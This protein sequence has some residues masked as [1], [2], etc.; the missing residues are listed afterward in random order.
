L[1]YVSLMAT[2]VALVPLGA[3]I[4]S[5]LVSLVGTAAIIYGFGKTRAYVGDAT[6]DI[7]DMKFTRW[8]GKMINSILIVS[9]SLPFVIVVMYFVGWHLFTSD[10]RWIIQML[11]LTLVVFI[12]EMNLN[13]R[14]TA[15]RRSWIFKKQTADDARKAREKEVVV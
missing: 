5:L 14:I 9:L 4:G 10:P 11:G 12:L 6:Q 2:G 1:F 15:L 13:S 3:I 7:M 8:E